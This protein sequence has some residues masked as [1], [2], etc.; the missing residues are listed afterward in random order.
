M[1]ENKI[2]IQQAYYGEVNRAHS[3][4]TQTANDSEL[5][6]FLIAFSDRPAALP[7]GVELAPYLSGVSFS[8]Q[9]IFTKTFPDPFATRAGMVFTHALIL[10][11]SDIYSVNNLDDILSFFGNVVPKERTELKP[12]YLKISEENSIPINRVQPKFIQETISA[13]ISGTYPVL[14]SGSIESFMIALQQIWN[15]PNTEFRKKIKFRTSFTPS[16]LEGI[17][18]LT[19]VSIQK[20]FL[21]KWTEHKIVQSEKNE[22]VEIT[23]HSEALFLGHKKDNPFYSFLIEL[24]VIQTDFQIFGQ[25]DK[26][27]NDFIA[28]HKIE[29]AN[30]LRQDIRLLSK[31]SPSSS[32]GGKVKESFIKKL[33]ELIKNGKDSNIKAL[34]NIEWSTFDNGVA[35]GKGIVYDF[36]ANELFKATKIPLLSELLNIAC[37]EEPKIWWH[38][39]IQEYFKIPLA[40]YTKPLIENLWKLIDDSEQTCKNVFSLVSVSIEN[41]NSLR[42]SIPLKLKDETIKALEAI[43]KKRKWFLLHAD[44]L[45]KYLLTDKAIVKQ[46]VIEDSL[47]LKDSVGV[48]YL[49][50]KL[51]DKELISLTLATNVSK[52]ILLTVERIIKDKSLLKEIDVSVTCWRTIWSMT[53]DKTRNISAGIEGKEQAIISSVF[54]LLIKENPIQE[55][56]IQL[57]ANST[58]AD[59]TNY[60]Q[61]AKLWKVIPTKFTEIFLDVTSKK[62]MQQLLSGKVDVTTIENQLSIKITSDSFMSNFLEEHKADIGSVIIVYESFSNLKDDFL[63]DY[64]SYYRNPITEA[65]AKNLGTL[66]SKNKLSKSAKSI[67]E[68]SKYNHTFR[69]AFEICKDLVTISLWDSLFPSYDMQKNYKYEISNMP[70]TKQNDLPIVVILTAIQEEYLAVKEHLTNAVDSDRNNTDYEIGIFEFKGKAIANV[71]IRECGAKNTTASQETERAINYFNPNM[72]MFVGIAGSRK[73][74]DFKIGDVIFPDKIYYYEGGKAA[75]NSFKARPDAVSPTFELL[76]KAKKERKKKD[77]MAMIKGNYSDSVKADIGIIASGEQL[78]DHHDSEIG[79]I[80]HEHYNDSSAVEMEGYGFAKAASRQGSETKNIIVGVVR[81]ISDIIELQADK[82]AE[83]SIDRRPDNAKLFASDTAAAFAFWLILK[84]YE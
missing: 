57:I 21:P 54:D 36:I 84:T 63:S 51:N 48:K 20:E 55:V 31:I 52:L 28:L 75:L 5:T 34:R 78:I 18:D 68:K 81:G 61:R 7:P 8:K 66:V 24:N 76:E 30:I 11:I 49:S 2:I 29:D 33:E 37:T 77:W 43:S 62:I 22:Q 47:N 79:K 39:S 59:I 83:V 23:S 16:D 73:P 12:I 69:T 45:L 44:L 67:Y 1:E 38:N 35:K 4:I 46:L 17:K 72:M 53:L 14:F 27:Y 50:E 74:N 25:C 56:I 82:Q 65:D 26:V 42:N 41:E 13:F 32:D 80:L 71:I 70:Q 60:R 64:I 9:Y 40:N 19:I 15:S 58:F 10:N 6:S 3:C